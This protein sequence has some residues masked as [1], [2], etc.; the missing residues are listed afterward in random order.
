MSS[1]FRGETNTLTAQ[2]GEGKLTVMSLCLL[3]CLRVIMFIKGGG[4]QTHIRGLCSH[5]LLMSDACEAKRGLT[6]STGNNNV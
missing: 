5:H 2:A 1:D 4:K 3:L 6:G